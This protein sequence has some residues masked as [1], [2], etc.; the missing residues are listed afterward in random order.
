M[1]IVV[2]ELG[3]STSEETWAEDD[4]VVIPAGAIPPL[5]PTTGRLAAA[6]RG[7]GGDLEANARAVFT[8]ASLMSMQVMMAAAAQDL[9]V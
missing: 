6:R 5:L 2:V 9:M 1:A 8:E 3:E 7:G 4:D